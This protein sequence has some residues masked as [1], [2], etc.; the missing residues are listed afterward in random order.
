MKLSFN[1]ILIYAISIISLILLIYFSINYLTKKPYKII[2]FIDSDIH[3]DFEFEITNN[4]NN[5]NEYLKEY[6][7]IDSH[8]LKRDKNEI[9]I[10][11]ILKNLLQ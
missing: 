1:N 7:F 4:L 10:Q 9:N 5:I 2:N 3:E 8:L 6:L 11:I